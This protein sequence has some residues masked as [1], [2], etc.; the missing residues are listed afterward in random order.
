[1]P[2][3]NTQNSFDDDDSD[4]EESHYEFAPPDNCLLPEFLNSIQKWCNYVYKTNNLTSW[5]DLVYKIETSHGL[6][7]KDK[8]YVTQCMAEDLV[9]LHGMKT[10][11]PEK[12]CRFC[13]IKH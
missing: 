8:N 5:T 4:T 11:F 1:M 2:P 7:Q 6:T 12:T 13:A 10:F 9:Y 3:L